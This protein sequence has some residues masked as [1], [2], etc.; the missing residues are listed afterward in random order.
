MQMQRSHGFQQ[1]QYYGSEAQ[2]ESY[3]VHQ[4]TW[5]SRN[6]HH[7]HFPGMQ[8]TNGACIDSR[9]FQRHLG[10]FKEGHHGSTGHHGHFSDAHKLSFGGAPM[11]SN[12]SKHPHHQGHGPGHFSEV[13][14]YDMHGDA[15]NV[16]VD[17]MRYKHHNWG[18]GDGFCA[19]PY[20]GNMNNRFHKV[21]WEVKGV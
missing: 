19:N 18:G 14:R 15:E 1:H 17:E 4:E 3:E 12:R 21:E 5:S 20:A 7:N 13:N 16:K 11:F 2:E 8:M 9:D 6:G 10:I